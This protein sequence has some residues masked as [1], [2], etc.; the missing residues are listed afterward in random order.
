MKLPN[1]FSAKVRT[2]PSP[3][4]FKARGGHGQDAVNIQGCCPTVMGPG[5]GRGWHWVKG[6]QRENAQ[7]TPAL[8]PCV[9][10]GCSAHGL[11]QSGAQLLLLVLEQLE[12]RHNLLPCLLCCC[13]Q[14]SSPDPE[15]SWAAGPTQPYAEAPTCPGHVLSPG[16]PAG[17][18]ITSPCS[19]PQSPARPPC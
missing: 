10:Q 1:Y 15:H 12:E 16:C 18:V 19:S 11:L 7:E 5:I 9:L 13:P 14:H 17:D 2:R 6:S 8:A 3:S 4:A